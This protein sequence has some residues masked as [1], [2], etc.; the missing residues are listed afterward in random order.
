MLAP[1]AMALASIGM[2]VS[3]TLVSAGG[4]RGSEQVFRYSLDRA[5]RERLYAR[6]PRGERGA[7]RLQVGGGRAG[8]GGA[9]GAHTR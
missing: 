2:F 3:G 7:V 5:A 1:G 4:L 6:V 8:A 9:G